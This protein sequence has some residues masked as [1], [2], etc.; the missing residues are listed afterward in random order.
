MKRFKLDLY[1]NM[2]SVIKK[3]KNHQQKC[4]MNTKHILSILRAKNLDL[5]RFTALEF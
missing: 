5:K 4:Y 1:P 2:E 3:K